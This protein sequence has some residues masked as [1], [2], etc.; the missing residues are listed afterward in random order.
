MGGQTSLL[1]N[2]SHLPLA[3]RLLHRSF[4]AG[5]PHLPGTKLESLIFAS[6]PS[7]QFAHYISWYKDD[8]YRLKLTVAGLALLTIL[9]SIQSLRVSSQSQPVNSD[10]SRQCTYM[11]S[12]YRTF[13]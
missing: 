12:T 1:C 10:F 5:R 2:C 11:D 3:S 8:H 6:N 13:Y 4:S 9:K 7:G